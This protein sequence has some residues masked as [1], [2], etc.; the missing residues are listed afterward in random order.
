MI[1]GNNSNMQL[2][3]S[4]DFRCANKNQKGMTMAHAV[5]LSNRALT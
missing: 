3:A 4:Q 1:A 5:I 2:M